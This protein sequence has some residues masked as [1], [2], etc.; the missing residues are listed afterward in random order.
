MGAAARRKAERREQRA[1]VASIIFWHGG[2]P[3]LAVGA[4]LLPPNRVPRT[5]PEALVRHLP[6]YGEHP[7]R[8]DRV[9]VTAD[10]ELA[11]AFAHRGENRKAGTGWVYQVIP[12]GPVEVDPDYAAYAADHVG[13]ACSQARIVAIA[14]SPVDMTKVQAS[15]AAARYQTWDDGRLMYDQAG[16]INPS[17]EMRQQGITKADTVALWEPW[18]Q[19]EEFSVQGPRV[20]Q[21]LA[22]K[23]R[24]G[25]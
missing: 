12:V 24:R 18:T 4:M 23:R 22:E 6:N 20:M 15:A 1:A 10:R 2:V 11:R 21:Y 16:Y 9:Y 19:W 5:G 17:R 7:G 14:D 3:G 13:V 25:S 8:P